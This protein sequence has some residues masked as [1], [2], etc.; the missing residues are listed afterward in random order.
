MQKIIQFLAQKPRIADIIVGL[1]IIVGLLSVLSLR[2]NFLP[3]EPINFI[4]VNVVYQGAS[5][6]EVEEEVVDKI[7]DNLEGLN[8]IDRVTSTSSESFANIRIELLEDANPNEVLQDVNNAIDQITT[9]PANVE[10]PVVVK[11]EILNYTMTLG[12]VGEVSLNQLK[13]Y[14][15]SIKDE[16][17][18]SPN[19]SQVFISGFPDE[20]IEV[21]LRENDLRAYQLTFDEVASAIQLSNIKASGG[22]IKT[23][24]QKVLI[25]LD[26]RAYYA[27]GLMNIVVKATPDGKVVRLKEVAEVVNQFADKPDKVFVNGKRAVTLKIFSRSQEDI[28]QNAADVNAF[29]QKFNRNHEGVEAIIIEDKAISLSDAIGTL[30]NNAWQGILLVLLVLGLFL[31]PRVAFWVAFKIPVAILGMFI[32]S[33]FYDLTINQVSLFGLIIV[34]GVIVDDGVVVAENIYQHFQEGKSAL[35]AAVDGTVEVIPAILASLATTALAFSL[36][37][38]L[39]GQLG[40]YFSDISFV[41]CGTLLIAL[42]ES[43]LILPIHI[44]R[45]KTLTKGYQ[46]W[47]LTQWT[48]NSLLFVRDKVYKG[49]I[50]F[51]VKIPIAGIAIVLGAMILT[52]NAMSSGLIKGTFFPT[53][54]QDVITAKLELPL[55]TDES[56]TEAKMR[57]IEKKIWEVN[58]EYSAKRT[59]GK[60]VINYVERITGPTSNE[61]AL[62]IYMLEG[63]TRGIISFDIANSIREAVGPIPEATNLSYGSIAVFGKPVSIALIGRNAD[64]LRVAKQKLRSYFENN[65]EVKDVT[66]TDKMGVPEIDVELTPKATFLGLA[67][68]QVFDQV[69]KGFFGVEAQSLQRGDEEVKVW[70]RYDQADRRSIEDLKEVRFSTPTGASYPL[71]E[72]ATFSTKNSVATINHQ[73]GIREIR[74]EADVANLLVSVPNVLAEAEATILKDIQREFPEIRYTL[75]GEARLSSKTQ[76]SSQGPSTIVFIFMIGI[77]LL[78]F[79]SISKTLAVLIML[80]FAF[81][82]VAWGT[83]LHNIPVSIFSVLGMIALWGILINNGL[84]LMAT[85]N[86]NIQEGM[87]IGEAMRAAAISRF[88]PIILTTITTV[89]GLAPLLLNNS[90]SAQFL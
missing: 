77:L 51:F 42:L 64:N 55:G 50:N 38:F 90:I 32:L 82:G 13:D 14:A 16:L 44:A 58:E 8:G 25:R 1:T 89:F 11:E 70:L 18:F 41:V 12:V 65:K 61:G 10:T 63:D 28:L 33:N 68:A 72:L 3:P 9:F 5:P 67:E 80:P 22:E 88:R 45:S 7:E 85:Y 24:K 78:S 48:N 30:Q 73:N 52:I 46:P 54:D 17:T 36:F 19:L 21:R 6:Q 49:I 47:K 20:E 71:S 15:E 4:A 37:F 86:D 74:V 66:D 57:R 79:R 62:N 31:D 43:M 26:N 60:Q 87:S 40:D 76:N 81:V 35:N 39:D 2:S 27:N 69:R 23:D 53:I 34:L 84:V 83:Y 59:D 29:V 56:I 75:E